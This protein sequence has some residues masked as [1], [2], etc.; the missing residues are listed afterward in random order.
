MYL[1]RIV[2]N[3][4]AAELFADPKHPYSRALL[5]ANPMP[6]PGARPE[7]AV[8]YGEVPSP[9]APPPGCAFH[10][11]CTFSRGRLPCR[12]DVPE[13]RQIGST[14]VH[15]SRCHYAEELAEAHVVAGA[16]AVDEGR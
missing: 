16:A 8:L 14:A 10:P 4:P 13:L 2:E 7:A 9:L 1:G 11:R 15:A 12:T 3:A 5:A 6:D